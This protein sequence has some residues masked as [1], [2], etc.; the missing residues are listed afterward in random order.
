MARL[1]SADVDS[2]ARALQ[3]LLF[4]VDGV[5]TDSGVYVDADGRELKRFSIKDGLAIAIA[6]QFGLVTG[7][8]SSRASLATSA[9]AAE[10]GMKIVMQG[11]ASKAE[12]L[13]DILEAH[14][15]TAAEVAYMGDDLVDLTVL[16][17]VGLAGCPAD[18][19]AEVLATAHWVSARPGGQGAA[20]EFVELILRARGQWDDVLSQFA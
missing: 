14:N 18:A 15:I 17:Q 13:A 4:D 6:P 16:G 2:R 11:V 8:L 19:A 20:R 3:L 10:L 5:L 9:R 7:I 1:N 12:A